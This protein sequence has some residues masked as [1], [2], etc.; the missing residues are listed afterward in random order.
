VTGRP[1][2]PATGWQEIAAEALR[3]IHAR[4]WPPGAAIPHETALAAEFGASRVTVNRALRALAEAGWL[5]RRRRAGTR[6]A[7]HPVRRAR[8]RIPI[9]RAEVEGAGRVYGHR[10]LLRETAEPP[11]EVAARMGTAGPLLHLV[12]LHLADGQ[13]HAHEDRWA[14]P[15]AVPGLQDADLDAVSANEWLVGNAPLTHGDYEVAAVAAGALAPLF[16][17]AAQ[18][19]LVAVRRGTWNGAV[20]I[21][22][23]LLTYAPGHRLR[24]EL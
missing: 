23:V 12:A 3:R 15:A 4:E 10:L 21:T 17:C 20:P 8:F 22:D 16:G 13:V 14:N 7:L 5:D 19:P 2:R 9:L 24:A 6:V 11:A 18:T 1:R